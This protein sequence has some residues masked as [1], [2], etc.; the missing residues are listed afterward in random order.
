M[1]IG[2]VTVYNSYN[3]GSFLQAYALYRFLS[4]KGHE[5]FFVERQTYKTN[6]LWYRFL[7]SIKNLVKGNI[8]EAKTIIQ[9]Y[10]LFKKIIRFFPIIE[11]TN[12]LDLIITGS[13]TV[14]NL[15]DAYFY[16]NW[17]RYWGYDVKNK[18]ITYAVSAGTTPKEEFLKKPE[19]KECINEFAG[20]SV[21]D[22]HTYEI[23]KMLLEDGRK[24]EMVV[25]PTM[26]VPR[27]NY[28]DIEKKCNERNFILVYY[29]GNMLKELAKEIKAF[30]EKENM[31]IITF[32][33]DIPFEPGLMLGYYRAADYVITNTFHGNIFSILYNKRFV[34]FGKEKKKVELLLQ[35]FELGERLLDVGD[36][37][38]ETLYR[39][40]DYNRTNEIIRQK[41]RDSV[42]YLERFLK[43][44]ESEKI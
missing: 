13:D 17:K 12:S 43:Q 2:I 31:K 7:R 24:P 14:W 18:K 25:D 6:K 11:D 29:F 37:L 8:H 15:D 30:A 20:I 23:A 21:R 28:Q 9:L 10:F 42:K 4:E 19:F 1:R 16:S 41:R 34:S 26:L 27:E 35:D 5:V 22:S 32:G 38:E 3:C 40:I 36:N 44:L 33:K 39:G